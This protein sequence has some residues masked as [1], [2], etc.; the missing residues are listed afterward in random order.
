MRRWRKR[1]VGFSLT[2]LL[3]VLSILGLLASIVIPTATRV[4]ALGRRAVCHGNLRRLTEAYTVQEAVVREGGYGAYSAILKTT[5]AGMLMPHLG[6]RS[7]ALLCPETDAKHYSSKPA[8]GTTGWY[9]GVW[10]PFS[11][12]PVWESSNFAA[13][14]DS[15]RV[16]TVWKMNEEDYA[17][18][19]SN[20]RTGWVAMEPNKDYMPKYTPGKDPRTYWF[21]FEDGRPG[22]QDFVGPMSEHDFADFDVKVTEKAPGVYE[23]EC[24]DLGNSVATH[25]IGTTD[26]DPDELAEEDSDDRDGVAEGWI[27]NPGESMSGYGPFYFADSDTNYGLNKKLNYLGHHM[28]FVMDYDA[29][30]CDPDA[31]EDSDDA[32][33]KLMAPRHLGQMCASFADGGVRTM[34]PN[35]LTPRD[36]DNYAAIWTLGEE[37]TDE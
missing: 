33:E 23:I 15:G 5:W 25:W 19:Q 31:G 29:L 11:F 28:V 8:F 1:V 20:R 27:E 32:F 36:P 13:L 9:G 24:F 21:S 22:G 17:V 26:S 30:M 14:W 7:D 16:P 34:W 12:E 10:D 6:G 3:I 2:E 4:M 18:F 35:E 37:P